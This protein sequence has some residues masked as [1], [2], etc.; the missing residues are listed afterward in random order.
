MEACVIS[1]CLTKLYHSQS[2]ISVCGEMER[3]GEEYFTVYL[4][5]YY[6]FNEGVL[7][8]EVK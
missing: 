7:A 3:F 6:S 5:V 1:V 2:S 8:L 4:K